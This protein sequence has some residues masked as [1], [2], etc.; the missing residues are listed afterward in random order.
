[1]TDRITQFCLQCLAG[2]GTLFFF[3][4]TFYS[5][6]YTK[7]MYTEG[8]DFAIVKDNPW[9]HLLADSGSSGCRRTSLLNQ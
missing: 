3:F 7:R 4:F 1:M 6:R 8:E 9:I 5:L 2:M